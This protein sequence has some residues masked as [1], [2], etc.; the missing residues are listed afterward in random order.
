MGCFKSPHGFCA[1]P[2]WNACFL[3]RKE[4]RVSRCLTREW[5]V[6]LIDSH[7]TNNPTNSFKIASDVYGLEVFPDWFRSH[8]HSVGDNKEVLQRHGLFI[9]LAMRRDFPEFTCCLPFLEVKNDGDTSIRMSRRELT[10][11]GL[12]NRFVHYSH[13]RSFLRF[14]VYVVPSFTI[15]LKMIKFPNG[16]HHN[17]TNFK[18]LP[19]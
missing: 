6:I 17:T 4:C 9:T 3:L 18:K 12:Q 5:S 2:Q 8:C 19:K 15:N 14:V 11:T 7:Y 10:P 13:F 16:I 1:H